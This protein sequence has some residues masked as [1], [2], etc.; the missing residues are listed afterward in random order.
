MFQKE[1]EIAAKLVGLAASILKE[2]E[3]SFLQ[4]VQKQLRVGRRLSEKQAAWIRSLDARY[5]QRIPSEV[6][7]VEK[8]DFKPVVRKKTKITDYKNKTLVTPKQA[9]LRSFKNRMG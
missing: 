9:I 1:Q 6:R 5:G 2:K 8:K 4:S 7:P 3:F